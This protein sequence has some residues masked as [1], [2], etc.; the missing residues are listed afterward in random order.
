[1]VQDL[2]IRVCL[3]DGVLGPNIVSQQTTYSFALIFPWRGKRERK[4]T[5]QMKDET[6]K[7]LGI[8]FFF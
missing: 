5:K 1:V 3:L 2:D 6:Q 4:R 7:R 8:D